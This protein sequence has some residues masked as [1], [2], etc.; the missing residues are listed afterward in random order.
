M[1]SIGFYFEYFNL[2]TKLPNANY[3]VP[4]INP[5]QMNK[6]SYL[7]VLCFLTKDLLFVFINLNFVLKLLNI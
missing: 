4:F 7:L 5:F 2:I 6:V 1:K 3:Q